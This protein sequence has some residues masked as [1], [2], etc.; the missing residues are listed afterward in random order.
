MQTGIYPAEFGRAAGQVN[1]STKPGTNEYHGTV[2]EFLRNDK[3]DARDYDF[4]SATRSATN[5]SPGKTPYRQNQYGFTLGGPVQ[6][7]KVFNGKNRLFFMS[8]WEGYKSRRTTTNYCH[9]ADAGDAER[10]LFLHPLC[11]VRLGG[12]DY[13]HRDLPQHHPVTFPGNN[14]IPASRL[15]AGSKLL[16]F[17]CA[18]AESDRR[19]RAGCPYRNYQ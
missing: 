8:N 14:Q 7:P 9:R 1:V 2:S 19:R 11:R 13:A 4:S 12:S 16:A 18:T 15:S 5:P 17:V 3:L 10:R 6:I